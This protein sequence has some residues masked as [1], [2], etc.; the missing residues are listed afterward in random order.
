MRAD[1]H[2]LPDIRYPTTIFG[3]IKMNNLALGQNIT[4]YVFFNF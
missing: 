3:R 2:I 1:V 4:S